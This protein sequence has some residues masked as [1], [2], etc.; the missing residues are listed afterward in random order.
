[1]KNL[2]KIN[3]EERILLSDSEMKEVSGGIY[4]NQDGCFQTGTYQ[5]SDAP[6]TK[7]GYVGF[8]GFVLGEGGGCQ[9]II[10]ELV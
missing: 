4:V 8:C 2:N 10:R 6:C 1:M 5:C 9:C 7:S 3:P